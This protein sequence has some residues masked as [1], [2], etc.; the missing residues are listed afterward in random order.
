MKKIIFFI[1]LAIQVNAQ[2][3][4]LTQIINLGGNGTDEAIKAITTMDGNIAILGTTTSNNGIYAGN[5]GVKDVF[6]MKVDTL[7][8]LIWNKMI[9]GSLDDTPIDFYEKTDGGFVIMSNTNSIDFDFT[10]PTVDYLTWTVGGP[11]Q[12]GF[13][14]FDVSNDGQAIT[15]FTNAYHHNYSGI[16]P[17]GLSLTLLPND[18]KLYIYRHTIQGGNHILNA[19]QIINGVGF[20]NTCGR[21]TSKKISKISNGTFTSLGNISG[22]SNN[23]NRPYG[24]NGY[25]CVPEDLFL[26]NY[27]STG[28]VNWT[29]NLG[30]TGYDYGV[31]F[32]EKNGFIYLVGNTNSN[33]YDIG[34]NSGGMDIYVAKLDLLGNLI[35]DT[36][37]AT[38]G[39]D[40]VSRI[41]VNS[42]GNLQIGGF[43]NN[44]YPQYYE[45]NEQLNL[46]QSKQFSTAGTGAIKDIIELNNS[47]YFLTETS[48]QGPVGGGVMQGT[49]LGADIKLLKIGEIPPLSITPLT[50]LK[51]CIGQNISLS[52]NSNLP[53]NTNYTVQLKRGNTIL[54]TTYGIG[55]NINIYI[56]YNSN[57]IYGTDYYVKVS[58]GADSA[59]TGFLTIGNLVYNSNNRF[60]DVNQN[61]VNSVNICVGKSRDLFLK[62][63]DYNNNSISNAIYT[64]SLNNTPIDTNITG[65]YN[66]NLGGQYSVKA[67]LGGCSVSQYIYVN[68]TNN[69]NNYI[70]NFGFETICSGQNRKLGSNYFSN[71]AQYQWH[72]NNQ[73]IPNANGYEFNASETG[74]YKVS[75]TESGC[76]VYPGSLKLTFSTALN[77]IINLTNND[78]TICNGSYKYMNVSTFQYNP[79]EFQYQWYKDGLLIPGA[80]LNNYGTNQ[81][82]KYYVIQKQGNCES[83]SRIINLIS[84]NKAQK[85]DF[86]LLQYNQMC[87]G[88]TVRLQSVRQSP[89]GNYLETMSIYGY[90][91]KDGV[92]VS[93]YLAPYY[94]ANSSGSYKLVVAEGTS[95]SVESDPINI[96]I[97]TMFKPKVMSNDDRAVVCGNNL[98]LRLQNINISHNIGL[99][100]QWKLNGS[101]ILGE[102]SQYLNPYFLSGSANYS[103]VVNYGGCQMESDPFSVSA[104][105]SNLSLVA[106]SKELYCSNALTKI[107]IKEV[108][109]YGYLNSTSWY[110]DGVLIPNEKEP[111]LYTSLPGVYTATQN[112]GCIGTSAPLEIKTSL[113]TGFYAEAFE[114]VNQGQ[115]TTLTIASCNGEVKWYDAQTDGKML[116]TGPSYTTTTLT[117]NTSYWATC[118]KEYCE[119]EPIEI[120]VIVAAACPEQITHETSITPKEYLSSQ[121]IES[122]IDVPNGVK[123][124]A[125]N[126]IILSPGFSAGSNEVFEAVIGGCTN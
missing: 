41:K 51:Y 118:L 91:Y 63:Y 116:F 122:S 71:T 45:I 74:T 27:S 52:I 29:K 18:N 105:T 111:Y 114:T 57:I 6:L 68:Q 126:H 55:P 83:R 88:G 92:Q 107:N 26:I 81:P 93:N 78:S 10:P 112:S 17:E 4:G 97:G 19:N 73:P 67:E 117:E 60:V 5:H 30:G 104:N 89:Y 77:P 42:A 110:R 43:S 37:L 9:G 46:I 87:N 86:S 120:Q 2:N 102:T 32:I 79:N 3:L 40:I 75:V 7:G 76:S 98:N 84:S 85:P 100:Y 109:H 48:N 59:K 96:T 22:A 13:V 123:Y 108:Y 8:N 119:S 62:A 113:P 69:I 101:N 35:K 23:F 65:S 21:T 70:S 72:L 115:T 99:T 56:P 95:C 39:K 50:T 124:S 28:S 20:G 31:D 11:N 12:G 1:F 61:I 82:G 53:S 15:N 36:T 54:N 106:T 24:F 80:T 34:S 14:V 47:L 103:L 121:T 58:A 90:W 64:W 94:D 16:K 66:V 125:G 44:Y 33:D 38:S 49:T 25:G